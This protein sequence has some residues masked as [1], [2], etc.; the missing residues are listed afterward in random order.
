LENLTVITRT[1]MPPMRSR[2]AHA[3]FSTW[4]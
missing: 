4:R 3:S 1:G 2:D